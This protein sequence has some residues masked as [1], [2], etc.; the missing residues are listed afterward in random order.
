M[1]QSVKQTNKRTTKSKKDFLQIFISGSLGYASVEQLN[2]KMLM[3]RLHLN[4][5]SNTFL[6][7]QKWILSLALE[8]CTDSVCLT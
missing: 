5:E 7:K 8:T 1:S 4:T 2:V 3:L 6:K